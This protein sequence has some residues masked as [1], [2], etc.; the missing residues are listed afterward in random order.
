MSKILIV[1]DS[2]FMRKILSDILVK[3][4]YEDIVEAKDGT[5]AIE[6]F[7]VEKPE[8]VILDIIMPEIDGI[9]VLKEII[10][11]GAQAIVVSAVGQDKMIDEV[12]SLGAKGYVIKPFEE[13]Q[14][15]DE[16]NKVLKQ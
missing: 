2:S 14:V 15:V 9:E 13:K 16:V 1:D 3:N 4:G 11:L 10:P 6:K 12:M 5:E 7:K 8:L